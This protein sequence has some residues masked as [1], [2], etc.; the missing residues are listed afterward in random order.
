MSRR[1]NNWGTER[2]IIWVRGEGIFSGRNLPALVSAVLATYA[3][4]A[5]RYSTKYQ[6]ENE[7]DWTKKMCKVIETLP[8]TQIRVHTRKKELNEEQ[9]K[10]TYKT[11]T[12]K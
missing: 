10:H 11:Q 9:K 2:E 3:N 8:N 1:K 12:K 5:V 6:W 4:P 7:I